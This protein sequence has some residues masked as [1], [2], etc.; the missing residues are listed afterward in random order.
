M[1]PLMLKKGQN[2]K[3]LPSDH[4]SHLSI[5]SKRARRT[6]APEM[7]QEMETTMAMPRK[8]VMHK[9]QPHRQS[10]QYHREQ[11]DQDAAEKEKI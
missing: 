3:Q 6:P 10:K 11:K 7:I 9:N 5:T 1:R 2:L 4:K 8:P